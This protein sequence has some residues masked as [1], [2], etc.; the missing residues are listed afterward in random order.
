MIYRMKKIIK[1]LLL[2]SWMSLIF[3]LSNQP[4]SVSSST[5]NNFVVKIFELLHINI[6]TEE[7]LIKYIGFIRKLA[8]FSEFAILA[9]LSYLTI[10]D[11]TDNVFIYN[12]I[13][14]LIY[15]FSDEIHQLFIPNR[16][17][18]IKDVGIDFL[19]TL[20]STILIHF[21]LGKWKR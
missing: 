16:H 10:V 9:V 17:C 1:L 19:G 18:S 15:A 2:L 11:Y 4:G 20:I 12:L 6:N 7:F 8:H 21:L 3:Y 13:F 14:G 5:S